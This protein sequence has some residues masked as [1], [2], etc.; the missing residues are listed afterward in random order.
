MPVDPLQIRINELLL[1]R[2]AQFVRV[3]DLESRINDILGGDP[4]PFARP[5][6]PSDQRRKPARKSASRATSAAGAK[7]RAG[8]AQRVLPPQIRR[9]NPDSGEVSYRVTYEQFGKA[10][11]EIHDQP[12]ALRTLL[13]SQGANLRVLRIEAIN[14]QG[15]PVET[16]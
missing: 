6:L 4:Y 10:V 16:L 7:G 14:A 11:T 15:E 1:A 2:E 8:E 12:D 5:A 13:A 3:H 9:L